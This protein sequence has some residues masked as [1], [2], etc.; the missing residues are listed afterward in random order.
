MR[1]LRAGERLD[2]RHCFWFGLP[3]QLQLGDVNK[4]KSA[5]A[6][7]IPAINTFRYPTNEHFE[8]AA[9]DVKRLTE[10]GV[11]GFQIDSVYFRLFNNEE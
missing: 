4:L 8:L 11:D 2:L 1:R 6:L 9:E 10:E 3:R 5:G 7:I